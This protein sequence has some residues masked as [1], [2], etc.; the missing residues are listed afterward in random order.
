MG[1]ERT[2]AVDV[3][4]VAASNRDLSAAV[5]AGRFR[6]DLYFRLNVFP[7]QLPP[8]RKR[9]EDIG[10]LAQYFPQN[11][12]RHLGRPIPAL[13]DAELRALTSYDWPGNV[14]ELKNVIERAAILAQRGP[15]R[16]DLPA[17]AP[18]SPS[19][20]SREPATP[21]ALQHWEA[22]E[23]AILEAALV[24]ARW[25]V[26]G[27]DGATAGLVLPPTTL[28]SKMKQLGLRRPR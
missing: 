20:A 23:R 27:R 16:L 4:V 7:I 10:L 28:A 25:K 5:R 6:G 8:L 12:A 17:T 1:D 13:G 26:Y 21:P 22:Q 14:R 24:A 2:R 11:A 18:P 3:R 15:F 19:P 9:Q